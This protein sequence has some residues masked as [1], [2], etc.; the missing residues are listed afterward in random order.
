MLAPVAFTFGAG[1]GVYGLTL[2][3][4]GYQRV[5]AA[6]QGHV[7][8]VQNAIRQSGLA[9]GPVLAGICIEAS[10]LTTF[11]AAVTMAGAALFP[12]LILS[13]T[14]WAPQRDRLPGDP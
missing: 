14:A 9:V 12:L 8:A 10:S 13:S 3:T 6:Q 4:I 1:V 2:A 5:P 11:A 7:F